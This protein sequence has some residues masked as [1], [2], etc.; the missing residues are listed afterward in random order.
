[1]ISWAPGML[2][3]EWTPLSVPG[4]WLHPVTLGR[5]TASQIM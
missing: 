1:M 3:P 2:Y 5:T 4:T